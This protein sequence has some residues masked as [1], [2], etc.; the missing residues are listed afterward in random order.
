MNAPQDHSHILNMTVET[1]GRDVLQAL[2]TEIK[3]MPDVWPKLSEAKQNDIIDRLRARVDHNV[4]MAVHLIASNGRIVVAG[5]LDQITIKDGVKAVVKFGGS[6]PNL[7]ELYDA[8]G[9]SVL[10]VVASP[11]EHTG[12]MDEIKGESDQRG[13]SM[14]PEYHEN[15]GG[16]MPGGEGG[17]VIEG[18]VRAL[19]APG[20]ESVTDDELQKHFELGLE[21]AGAGKPESE[22]P[23][24]RHELVVEWMRGHKAYLSDEEWSGREYTGELDDLF[25]DAVAYVKT[26]QECVP[27]KLMRELGI[28][29]QRAEFIIMQMAVEGIVSELD[30]EGKRTVLIAGEE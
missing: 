6:A 20:E 14:G 13:L 8:A 1:I 22:C 15:D 7:H 25:L 27:T 3:L 16:G 26:T 4:K 18:E 29:S 28:G 11:A 23:T 24:V 21:A 17:V 10:I 19:P 2:V 30:A 5:D 12:G 9:K